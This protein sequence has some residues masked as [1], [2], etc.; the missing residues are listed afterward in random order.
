MSTKIVWSYIVTYLSKDGETL[1]INGDLKTSYTSEVIARS[2]VMNYVMSV[3]AE[4]ENT[5]S[6][7]APILCFVVWLKDP[8][9]YHS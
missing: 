4:I 6:Y 9:T 7:T 3:L 2:I 8:A 5:P 1:S